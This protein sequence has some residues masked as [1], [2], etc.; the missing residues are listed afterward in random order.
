MKKFLVLLF[1]LC[2]LLSSPALAEDTSKSC[3][4]GQASTAKAPLKTL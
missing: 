1:S 2:M 3:D 4:M